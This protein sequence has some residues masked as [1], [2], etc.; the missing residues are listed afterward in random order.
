MDGSYI[1]F[2]IASM[3]LYFSRNSSS[4]SFSFDCSLTTFLFP[5][6]SFPNSSRSIEID[7][8]NC[9]SSS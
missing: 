7:D 2:S 9:T 4:S 6:N 1:L 5:S 8:L 3:R